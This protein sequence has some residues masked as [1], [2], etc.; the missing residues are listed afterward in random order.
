MH[1]HGSI[2]IKPIEPPLLTLGLG[3]KSYNPTFSEHIHVA[4]QINGN[5][6]FSHT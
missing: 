1:Q 6:E 3:S 4:Y 5:D 2:Y